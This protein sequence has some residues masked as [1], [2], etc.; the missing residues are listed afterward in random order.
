MTLIIIILVFLFIAAIVQAVKEEEIKS[1]DRVQL[2]ATYEDKLKRRRK[3][4]YVICGILALGIILYCFGDLEEEAKVDTWL[5]GEI[6]V[7]Q[8]TATHYWAFFCT[9]IGILGGIVSG[10][11]VYRASYYTRKYRVM[12]DRQYEK[13]QEEIKQ[14]DEANNQSSFTLFET[15]PPCP[16]C[17]SADTRTSDDYRAKQGLK[18]AGSV[19]LGAVLGNYST[20]NAAQTY[21]AKQHLKKSIKIDKEYRCNRCGYVWKQ[22]TSEQKQVPHKKQQSLPPSAKAQSTSIMSKEAKELK[23]LLNLGILTPEEYEIE[24][25][26]L[27]S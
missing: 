3:G 18:M 5:F 20:M 9:L 15:P 4:L 17:G 1:N 23:E 27:K 8:W 2:L 19:V 16:H 26:K 21:Y 6:S 11:L 22:S 24:A 14:A 13:I 10:V 7:T 25:N 12:N